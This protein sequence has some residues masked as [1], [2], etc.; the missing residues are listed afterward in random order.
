M[1]NIAFKYGNI[2]FNVKGK[3]RAIVLLHGFLESKEI[4]SSYA[5]KLSRVY[6]VIMVDL[7]GHGHSDCFGYVHHM[8]L[9]AQSVKAVLDSLHLRRYILVGHSMGGYAALAFAELYT[10]NLKGLLLFHSTALADSREKKRDRERA[11]EFVKKNPEVYARE[12]TKKLFSPLN[13][14]LFRDKVEFAQSISTTTSQQGI[15]AALEGMK[16]RKN[17]EGVLRQ[18]NYPVMFIAGKLD[19]TI[20]Y[21]KIKPLF[22]HEKNTYTQ[23]LENAGHMGFFEAET[24]TVRSTKKFAR[25]CFRTPY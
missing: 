7:P 5:E 8:E 9:M 18:A 10:E 4:W 14:D 19:N 22:A 20:L 17:K 3:G 11:I 6:K 13:A 21:E 16:I 1:K 25:V 12:A 23:T 2:S 15:I 24:E